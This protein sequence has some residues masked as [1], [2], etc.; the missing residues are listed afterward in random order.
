MN[1]LLRMGAERRFLHP[2]P[3]LM[4]LD[5]LELTVA[6]MRID[7]TSGREGE[8]MRL[9]QSTLESQGWMVRRIPVSEGRD[10]IVASS[11]DAPLVTLSTHLDTV[12]PFIVPRVE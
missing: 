10:N 8:V 9:A 5:P 2:R 1:R 7:S 12:P 11:T 4:P 3:D 6:L